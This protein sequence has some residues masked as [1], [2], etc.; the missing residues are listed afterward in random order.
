M[1]KAL[2]DTVRRKTQDVLP[3]L[4]E[5]AD[6]N[7]AD[8]VPLSATMSAGS[9]PAAQSSLFAYFVADVLMNRNEQDI[10]LVL[11]GVDP[12]AER[13]AGPQMEE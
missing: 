10:V 7:L 1:T 4:E 6:L 3:V 11:T 13:I 9:S 12:T 2:S 8:V 5:T